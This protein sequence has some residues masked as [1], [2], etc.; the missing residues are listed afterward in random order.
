MANHFFTDLITGASLAPAHPTLLLRGQLIRMSKA[1]AKTPVHC[2]AALIIKTWNVTRGA[3]HS[4]PLRY[5]LGED[6]P[7]IL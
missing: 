2:R 6:F 4:S 7:E 3:K 1:T 5:L